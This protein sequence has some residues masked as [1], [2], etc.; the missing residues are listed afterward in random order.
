MPN[1]NPAPT[2]PETLPEE[3]RLSLYT[4]L[5]Q[6]TAEQ[7][8]DDAFWDYLE[9]PAVDPTTARRLA[10]SLEALAIEAAH[11]HAQ[12][13]D[14]SSFL[15]YECEDLAQATA[16]RLPK[17]EREALAR[18]ALRTMALSLAR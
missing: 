13:P 6:I 7:G 12:Q 18:E 4:L 11:A 17:E 16:A 10:P 14:L 1:H 5:I 8:N 15:I 3:D 9:A 2:W